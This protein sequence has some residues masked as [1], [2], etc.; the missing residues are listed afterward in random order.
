MTEKT[1]TTEFINN[2]D[3]YFAYKALSASQIKTY[4]TGGAYDFWKTSVFNPERRETPETDA[5]IF[6]KLAHCMLFEPNEVEKRFLIMDWGTKTRGTKKHEEA[7]AANPDK[8]LVSPDEYQKAGKMLAAL[9]EHRVAREI[10]K[11]AYC[12][13]PFAWTDEQ[14]GL[15]CKAKIDAYK[16]TPY[17][18]VIIDYKTSSSIED[19]LRYG[20]K[21]QYPIQSAFY[22]E[23]AK[24][25]YGKEPVEFVFIIQSNKDG[26]EDKICVANVEVE[27]QEAA[28]SIMH[29]NM[30]MIKTKLENW[31]ETHDKNIWAA[32]PER[33][34]IR[35]SNWYMT[36]GYD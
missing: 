28:K 8:I 11:D 14:T 15:P 6:G 2:D 32:Y 33:E 18:L 21:L 22:C 23:A 24:A 30:Q 25:R 7:K 12:E 29:A 31:N 9:M 17:G 4:A 10:I 3:G 34:L 26:E 13:V 5:L 20:Q 27:T 1:N 16:N 36:N 35:Y 19:V